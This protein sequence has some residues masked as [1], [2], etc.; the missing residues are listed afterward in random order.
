MKTMFILL[1]LISNFVIAKDLVTLEDYVN[2]PKYQL[3]YMPKDMTISAIDARYLISNENK[4]II[5]YGV[6]KFGQTQYHKPL[7]IIKK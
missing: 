4:D 5:I 3:S 7:G 1:T 2:Q 6:N